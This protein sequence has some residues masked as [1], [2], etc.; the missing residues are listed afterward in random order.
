MCEKSVCNEL[1]KVAAAEKY[2]YLLF[3]YI[4]SES[5]S[6]LLSITLPFI[7]VFICYSLPNGLNCQAGKLPLWN[8][9]SDILQSGKWTC[10]CSLNFYLHFLLNRLC[11]KELTF[12]GL[13]LFHPFILALLKQFLAVTQ[14]AEKAPSCFGA[15]L[16]IFHQCR[17]RRHVDT[18]SRKSQ[19]G[20][21]VPQMLTLL[22]AESELR[23][24]PEF[25]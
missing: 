18:L 6:S 3:F 2:I 15:T 8:V 20:R 7:K 24:L 14:C 16:G 10:F 23:R 25:T 21:N 4:C 13:T 22:C 19:W 12:R 5:I 9:S 17:L 11:W 1:K